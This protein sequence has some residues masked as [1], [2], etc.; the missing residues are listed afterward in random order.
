MGNIDIM[1]YYEKLI[2]KK[3]QNHSFAGIYQAKVFNSPSGDINILTICLSRSVIICQFFNLI[4]AHHLHLLKKN[5]LF[6]DTFQGLCLP[7]AWRY[8]YILI[9]TLYLHAFWEELF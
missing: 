4:V 1:N 9:S 5:E 6:T 3:Y 8:N 7:F 2:T